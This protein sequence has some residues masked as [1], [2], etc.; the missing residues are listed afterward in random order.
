MLL[1]GKKKAAAAAGRAWRQP[2]SG[3]AEMII[4]FGIDTAN[5]RQIMPKT[6]G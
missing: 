2:A 6:K 4:P 1:T 3:P 5:R